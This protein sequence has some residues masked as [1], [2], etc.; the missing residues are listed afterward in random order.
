MTDRLI[1]R[2]GYSFTI[3]HAELDLLLIS[4]VK[5]S[6]FG[7]NITP[8]GHIIIITRQSIFLLGHL[9]CVLT[10]IPEKQQIPEQSTALDT[11]T[12]NITPSMQLIFHRKL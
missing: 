12:L 4:S 3:Q 10:A 9:Y 5:T 7:R 2:R 1:V 6:L 8:L 11:R